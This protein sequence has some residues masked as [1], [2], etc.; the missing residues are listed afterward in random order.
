ML[1]ID[2]RRQ[3]KPWTRNAS[4]DAGRLLPPRVL[5]TSSERTDLPNLRRDRARRETIKLV[6]SGFR[7]ASILKREANGV[8]GFAGARV[9]R[10]GRGDVLERRSGRIEYDGFSVVASPAL[11]ARH[12]LPQLRMHVRR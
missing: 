7:C 5:N 4:W 9:N 2:E 12:H 8:S 11:Q 1:L 6:R 10:R 3:S